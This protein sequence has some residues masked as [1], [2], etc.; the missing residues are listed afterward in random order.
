MAH[1]A[2]LNIARMLAPLDTPTMAGFVARLDEVNA[3]AEAASGFVWRLVG[4]GNDATSLRPFPDDMLIVNLSVWTDLEHLRDFVY[5]GDHLQVLRARKEWFSAMK[6]AYTVLWWIPEGH[7]P[8]VEQAKERLLHLRE[9]GPT[10]FAFSF[11]R[12]FAPEMTSA[13][14]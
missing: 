7:T 6:E 14:G 10:P 2:Q 13:F 4:E 5:S 9:H 8:T 1:L 12:S 3:L 11:A